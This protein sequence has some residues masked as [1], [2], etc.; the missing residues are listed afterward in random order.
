MKHAF[1]IA[2]LVCF[3]CIT[4]NAIGQ[5]LKPAPAETYLQIDGLHEK[6]VRVFGFDLQMTRPVDTTTGAIT[7][8][9]RNNLISVV[10]GVD[11]FVPGIYQALITGRGFEGAHV[12]VFVTGKDG[13]RSKVQEIEFQRIRLVSVNEYIPKDQNNTLPL[14]D[15]RFT[16]DRISWKSPTGDTDWAYNTSK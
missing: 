16:C 9:L 12:Q 2:L 13:R 15:I 4:G 3:T 6:P 11:S 14:L 8:S 1:G 7:G 10:L 5:T